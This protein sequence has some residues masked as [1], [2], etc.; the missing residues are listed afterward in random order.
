M[1]S[2]PLRALLSALLQAVSEADFYAPEPAP[3]PSVRKRYENFIGY[4]GFSKAVPFIVDAQAVGRKALLMRVK[5]SQGLRV[6][7][8][9]F[10]QRL[11]QTG[12]AVAYHRCRNCD[13]TGTDE[14]PFR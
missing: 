13:F 11:N 2:A 8:V 5:S 9:R 12:R 14:H 3:G 4:P 10:G 6:V 1:S 7:A